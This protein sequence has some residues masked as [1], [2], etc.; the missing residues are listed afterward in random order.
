MDSRPRRP[1]SPGGRRIAQGGGGHSSTGTLIYP[2]AFDQYQGPSRSSIGFTSGPRTSAER[3]IQPR[4]APRYRPESPRKSSRDDYL[5][6]PRR[7]TLDPQDAVT[8]RPLSLITPSS[9]SRARPIITTAIERP[10]SPMT[11][12][13]RLRLDEDYYIQP[14]SSTREPRRNFTAGSIDTSRLATGD[15]REPS[16][17]RQSGGGRTGYNVNQPLV[18]PPDKDDRKYDYEYPGRREQM[19][20]DSIPRVRPR[21][22][23]SA[24]TRER[25]M[26]M[27]GLED[28]PT[29]INQPSR[30]TRP[31]TTME[32]RGYANMGRSASLRQGH[33]ARDDDFVSRDYPREDY[34]TSQTRKPSRAPVSLHQDSAERYYG[35]SSKETTDG[36]HHRHRK[37]QF[38]EERSDIKPKLK[39]DL[40]DY[41]RGNDDRKKHE[42]AHHRDHDSNEDRDRR[43]RDDSSRITKR[44]RGD[45]ISTNGL[46]ATAAASAAAAGVATEGVR[47]HHRDHDKGDGVVE[48]FKERAR[49]DD[50]D[51]LLAVQDSLEN[52]SISTEVSD[53][54][55]RERHRRRRRE[56]EEKQAVDRRR[57]VAQAV[58]QLAPQVV[59]QVIPSAQ[60]V[61]HEQGSYERPSQHKASN[62]EE[63][64]RS[65][66]HHHHHPRTNDK[67]YDS[68]KSSSDDLPEGR[69]RQVRVV[70]PSEDPREPEQPIKSILRQPK[71]RFP[72][73]PTP[74]REGVAPMKDAGA[75][76]IPPNARWTKIDRKLVNPEA[77]E[78][79]NERFEERPDHVIVL[80]VLKKEDIEAYALKTQEIRGKRGLLT[81]GG[82]E[83]H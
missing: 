45:E 68:D 9:P 28:Y 57:D 52:T 63:I 11:N 8:R 27:T 17:Y 26:S 54:E 1:L 13:N 19:Y 51:R 64:P 66:R 69:Q 12:P 16:G 53:E 36:R 81:M 30:D 39:D 43:S 5:I 22:D 20:R 29:R 59:P 49:D 4:V 76:G 25:P 33:R 61:L 15:R 74:V 73:D 46:L 47:R 55:R 10:P 58:P 21:R 37:H 38:D 35:E 60:N 44:D 80:R 48:P 72:E 82:H 67:E 31:P 79:G 56:K 62:T 71:E 7:Q 23:S 34:D 6:R 14:A 3:V 24:S 83:S 77:L 42:K 65:S 32:T 50:R 70:D 40:N 41:D 2:S 75:K 18:R 78:E